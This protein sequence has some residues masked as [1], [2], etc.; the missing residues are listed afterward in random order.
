MSFG[1]WKKMQS[2]PTT[3]VGSQPGAS[4]A[5]RHVTIVA[6]PLCT[7]LPRPRQRQ[8][9]MFRFAYWRVHRVRLTEALVRSQSFGILEGAG[10]TRGCF[11]HKLYNKKDSSRLLSQTYIYQIAI[12]LTT[13]M[14]R[15]IRKY[16]GKV[17]R[18]HLQTW[19]LRLLNCH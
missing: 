19:P 12:S 8:V 16:S 18:D 2:R 4:L 10:V 17:A 1:F 6:G 9:P 14:G 5:Y 11:N 13:S 7:S 15:L 3:W